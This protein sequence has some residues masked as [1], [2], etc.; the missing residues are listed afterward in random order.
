MTIPNNPHV[1]AIIQARISSSR[2]PG[3]V[4]LEI[5]GQPMLSWVVER[6]RMATII[7]EAVVAT[8]DDPSDDTLAAFCEGRAY[9]YVRGSLYDVLDRFYQA[10]HSTRADII[11]RITG[12]CPFI[13]PDL[14]DL[15]VQAY[16]GRYPAGYSRQEQ[17][18]HDAPWDFV[19]NRLPPPWK[20]TYPIG[21]DVEVCSFA[22]LERAWREAKEPHQREHVMPFLYEHASVID[23][24]AVP[25][26]GPSVWVRPNRFL[27][28]SPDQFR[29]LLLNHDQDH[30][31]LR[32]TVDTIEDL[33]LVRQVVSQI[34]RRKDFS[35]LDII[36]LFQHHP[37]LAQIN[38]AVQHKTMLDIDNRQVNQ[39]SEI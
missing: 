31:H 33:R 35:W 25:H 10:A 36:S 32:W 2:L 30:G 24:R 3:K 29:V 39:D 13:D 12:D 18:Q 28:A 1:V 19:A 21:L 14:I 38:A 37:E 9:S 27:Q 20:R 22:A 5:A 15:A 8:T 6:T 23:S 4:L 11:V 7:S 17:S 34:G 26:L 16:L